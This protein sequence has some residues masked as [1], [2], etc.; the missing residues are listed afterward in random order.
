MGA[1][2]WALVTKFGPSIGLGRHKKAWHRLSGCTMRRMF[3]GEIQCM[4]W[5]RGSR[6][7]VRHSV[8]RAKILSS[9]VQAKQAA[10]TKHYILNKIFSN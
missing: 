5:D 7:L 1:H 4:G 8:I 2:Y 6:V 10:A 9:K 3:E